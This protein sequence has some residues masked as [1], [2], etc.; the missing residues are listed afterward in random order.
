MNILLPE[1]ISRYAQLNL[2]FVK[3]EHD[4]DGT[5]GQVN[6]TL[7]YGP[8]RMIANNQVNYVSNIIKMTKSLWHP[9]SV[10]KSNPLDDNF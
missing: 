1:I 10:V 3:P 7:S 6:G 2:S 5:M 9:E 4:F 8:M